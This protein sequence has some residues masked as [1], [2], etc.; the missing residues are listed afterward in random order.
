MENLSALVLSNDAGVVGLTNRV[1]DDYGFDVNVVH[2]ASAARDLIKRGSVDLAVYDN[3]VDGAMDLVANKANGNPRM[4]FA[5]VRR[6]KRPDL[7]GRRIHFVVQKPFTADF[8][9]KS[10]KAAY[11]VMLRER[12]NAFR[13]K[14]GVSASS[15]VVGQD[16]GQRSLSN[17]TIANISKTGLRLTAGELL[18]LGATLQLGFTLPEDGELTV[19]SGVI[20]WACDNGGAG[21]RFNHVAPA[22]QKKLNLWIDS[23]LP[24]DSDFVPRSNSP[25]RGGTNA[26]ARPETNA[27]SAT[28]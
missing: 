4:V 25:W 6:E 20:V 28:T 2:T 8:F 22:D 17:V 19:V 10:L 9:V 12:R 18:P 14:L 1:F 24:I 15:A 3:D 23:K 5:M 13:Q 26:V 21:I 11:G 16:S 27:D 7:Q